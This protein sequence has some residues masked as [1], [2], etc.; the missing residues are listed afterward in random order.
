MFEDR[1][2]HVHKHPPTHSISDM[3][4]LIIQKEP[5]RTGTIITHDKESQSTTAD[6]QY[7]FVIHSITSCTCVH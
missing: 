1:G 5:L 4:Y 3:M 6:P 7:N 2:Y